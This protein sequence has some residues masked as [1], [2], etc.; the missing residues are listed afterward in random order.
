MVKRDPGG[1]EEV[2]RTAA[3]LID[4]ARKIKNANPHYTEWE[5]QFGVAVV[6][7]CTAMHESMAGIRKA[8]GGG[9]RVSVQP[10][11]TTYQVNKIIKALESGLAQIAEGASRGTG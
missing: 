3:D 8:V 7:I 6:A 2:G 5:C 11:M 10:V 1:Y 4:S 9:M